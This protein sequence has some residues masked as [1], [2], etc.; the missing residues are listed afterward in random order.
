VGHFYF[1]YFISCRAR[2][3]NGAQAQFGNDAANSIWIDGGQTTMAYDGYKPGRNIQL[4][5]SDFYQIKYNVDGVDHASAVYDGRAGKILSYKN[6]HAWVYSAFMR[7]R[8]I[9]C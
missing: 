2:I 8:S 7:T 3:K 1:N 4:T 5:N 6:E 9:I